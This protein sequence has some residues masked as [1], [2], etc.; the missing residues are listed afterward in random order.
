MPDQHGSDLDDLNSC[1]TELAARFGAGGIFITADAFDLREL[2]PDIRDLVDEA[3]VHL[4]ETVIVIDSPKDLRDTLG[5]DD[6]LLQAVA[7]ALSRGTPPFRQNRQSPE[8][9]SR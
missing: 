3:K 9:D 4:N 5:L 2:P 8:D 7:A 1:L 6:W